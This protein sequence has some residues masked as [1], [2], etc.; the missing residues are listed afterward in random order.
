VRQFEIWN[1]YAE[2]VG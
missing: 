1:N 2:G